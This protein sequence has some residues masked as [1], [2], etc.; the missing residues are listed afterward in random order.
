MKKNNLPNWDLSDI[1]KSPQDPKIEAD[2]K[3]YKKNTHAFNKK[4][5]GHLSQLDAQEFLKALKEKEKNCIIARRLSA[6][7]Y[8]NMV[9]QLNNQEATSFYQSI[10]ESL[11]E[12]GKETLFFTIELNC[13]DEKIINKWLKNKDVAFYRPWLKRVRQFKEHQLS[14]PEEKLLLEKSITSGEAWVRLYEEHSSRLTFKLGDKTY[15]ESEI[16]HLS[17]FAPTSEERTKTSEEI[18]RVYKENASLFTFIYNMILKDKAIEDKNRGFE[19]PYSQ[20][21]KS[22]DVPDSMVDT[23]AETVRKHYEKISH[24]YYRLKASWL[25]KE[26]LDYWDRS[27][28]LPFDDTKNYSWEEAVDTVLK[29]YEQFSPKL[30]KIADDFF[31]HNWIDVGPKKGK[32]GGAFCSPITTKDHPYLLLNFMGKRNDVLTLSHEL[33]HGCHHQLRI[34]NGELNE[35]S[36]MTSEEIASVFGEMLTFQ[37]LLKQAKSDEER[38]SLLASK[39]GDMIATACR[40]IAFFFFEKRTHDLRSKG[41]LTQETLAKIWQEELQAYMGPSVLIDERSTYIWPHVGHFFF[42][43]FYVYAYSFADCFVNSLYQVYQENN[44]EAF[45]DK[46]LELLSQTAIKDYQDI[47]KP[48]GIDPTSPNFWE[49]GLKLIESYVDELERLDKKLFHS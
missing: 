19:H 31:T 28:P 14:E 6:Y 22:E 42:L 41:E 16:T 36:R 12:Y 32:R 38:L 39:T 49:K 35:R 48:F 9:T 34:D 4:Y 2:L 3:K 1:Y 30:R 17:L 24:R 27:A 10:S 26:K 33:G 15:N 8:L 20:R 5:K 37:S 40:Q 23:L 45:E 7:A 46:Y 29:S 21:N 25:K 13:I 44:I 47:L 11:T 18:H 43:P